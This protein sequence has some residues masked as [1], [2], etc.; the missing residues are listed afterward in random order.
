M[1]KPVDDRNPKIGIVYLRAHQDAEGRS[2]GPQVM[3]QV[4]DP[5]GWNI[6]AVDQGRAYI[7]AVNLEVPPNIGS[8]Y[9]VPAR[10]VPPLPVNAP[11]LDPV[12]SAQ[13]VMTGL[14]GRGDQAQAEAMARK[15]GEGR[16]AVFDS[17]A[18]WSLMP[19]P[20]AP[21]P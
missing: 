8:P 6:E 21:A 11:L 20:A 3:Y 5:G 1:L 14:M 15:A 10:E 2:P 13:I 18:G 4:T 7:P 17:Q 16:I 9:V 19:S 12:K